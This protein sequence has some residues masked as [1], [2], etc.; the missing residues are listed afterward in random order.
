VRPDDSRLTGVPPNRD[1]AVADARWTETERNRALRRVD[2][3]FLLPRPGPSLSVCFCEGELAEAVALISGSVHKGPGHQA[4]G[5]ELAAAINPDAALLRT[6]YEAL[7][8]GGYLYLES[9][10]RFGFAAEHLRRQLAAAGYSDIQLLAP[11]PGLRWTSPEHWVP[12]LAEGAVR[13]AWQGRTRARQR[14][15]RWRQAARQILW[16]LSPRLRIASPLC[17]LARR[18]SPNDDVDE[19]RPATPR[20]GDPAAKGDSLCGSSL[21]M[22]VRE[23]WAGWGLG[24]APERVSFLLL[25]GGKRAVNKVVALAFADAEHAPRIAVKLARVPES[26]SGI[27]REA[28]TLDVLHRTR[29]GLRG[30]PEVVFCEQVDGMPLLGQTVITGRRM[31]T[32]LSAAT[33]AALARAATDWQLQLAGTPPK[34][35]PADLRREWIDPV[36]DDFALHFG[37]AVDPAML[38]EALDEVSGL[39]PLP[40]VVEQRDFSPWNL[41]V[42]AERTLGVLDWESSELRG[43]PVLDLVYLFAYMSVYLGGGFPSGRYSEC[44][45]EMLDSSTAIGEAAHTCLAVY[46][47]RLDIEPRNVRA[48]RLLTWMLHA[49]SGYQHLLADTGGHPPAPEQLR[50]SP[51][52]QLWEAEVRYGGGRAG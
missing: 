12:L 27:E 31:S 4:R 14:S 29:A 19:A 13:Y 32:V 7:Q 26:V 1:A 28:A 43:V 46:M 34:W 3:R 16:R 22:R 49:R 11:Q 38:R 51:Y 37:S 24:P 21:A 40:Q 52:I 15:V 33:A 10:S 2:W 35:S 41:L 5:C 25:T 18:P 45:R 42:T 30:V 6:A 47:R 17:A 36:I 39:G 23:G 50:A 9:Y 44:Y 20:R 48:L 8:P